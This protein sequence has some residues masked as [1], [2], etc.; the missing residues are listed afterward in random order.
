LTIEKKHDIIIK[1]SDGAARKKEEFMR[2]CF[3]DFGKKVCRKFPEK[4]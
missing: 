1:L 2:R 3:L 4:I